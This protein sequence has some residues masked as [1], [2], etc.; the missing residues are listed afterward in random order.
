MFRQASS[1]HTT[2]LMINGGPLVKNILPH[3]AEVVSDWISVSYKARQ[4]WVMDI[5]GFSKSKI[6]ISSDVWKADNGYNYSAVI[7]HWIN[8][9]GKLRTALLGFP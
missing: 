2:N 1:K 4:K 3:N 5:L 7:R 8:N 9:I 6:N